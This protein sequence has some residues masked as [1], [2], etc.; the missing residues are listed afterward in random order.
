MLLPRA[1][2]RADLDRLFAERSNWGRWGPD[3]ERGAFNLITNEVR[4]AAAALVRTGQVLSLSRPLPTGY[5]STPDAPGLHYMNE[6]Y[7]RGN[8][9]AASDFVGL[10]FHGVGTTHF[11][12]LGHMWDAR[13]MWNGRDPKQEVHIGG[14]TWSDIDKIGPVVTRGVLLDVVRH[15]NGDPVEIETPVHGWELETI[16]RERDLTLQPG[17]AL[18]IH[19]GRDLWERRNDR[20]WGVPGDQPRPG[21]HPSCMEFI[22]DVD[23]A[24]VVWDMHD[25]APSPLGDP[26]SVHS[27]LHWF[28]VGLIDNAILEQLADEAQKQSRN[29]FML[30]ASPLRVAKATGSPV[31]PVVIL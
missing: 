3:D 12:S 22:R 10:S 28:G 16:C 5:G 18:L 13:G 2:T 4:K 8:G 6:V 15:R 17:D 11:D 26:W 30:M 25:A 7:H 29:E 23:S 20:R 14:L 19:S 24:L 27:V 21:L 1:Y 9:G 31:N